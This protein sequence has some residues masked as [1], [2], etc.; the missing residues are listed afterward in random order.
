MVIF[1]Q[2]QTCYITLC[3]FL[4]SVDIL[5]LVFCVFKHSYRNC[6][7]VLFCSPHLIIPVFK[8]F[9]SLFLLFVVS[10]D[11]CPF[12]LFSLDTWLSLRMC[13][14]LYLK[15]YLWK[16]FRP[17]MKVSYLKEDLYLLL[18]GSWKHCQSR[19]ILTQVP[20]LRFT[21]PS[22][23][24]TSSK[25][26]GVLEPHYLVG[27]GLRSDL[28]SVQVLGFAF[29]LPST[30]SLSRWR[31]WFLPISK[32]PRGRSASVFRFL[33]LLHLQSGN[34]ILS[35]HIILCFKNVF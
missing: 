10:A 2:I 14:T 17:M 8:V 31:L 28:P 19:I 16:W 1:F 11:S 15:N 12:N 30:A 32:F 33:F 22:N 24:N 35:F 7:I 13:W 3:G 25:Y 18:P 29:C 4:F 26:S 34:F 6:F 9:M 23:L 20:G 27:E 21:G 5:M